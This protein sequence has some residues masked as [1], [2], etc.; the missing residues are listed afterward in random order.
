MSDRHQRATGRL[1]RT[2]SHRPQQPRAQSLSRRIASNI[3][4][5]ARYQHAADCDKES[6]HNNITAG[7]WL[8]IGAEFSCNFFLVFFVPF[9]NLVPRLFF[10]TML[11]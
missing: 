7:C 8:L 10:I 6:N 4:I 5:A 9:I 11:L 2:P 3:M 1:K